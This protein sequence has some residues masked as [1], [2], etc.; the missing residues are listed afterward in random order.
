MDSEITAFIDDCVANMDESKKGLTR[1]MLEQFVWY[2]I[3]IKALQKQIEEEGSLIEVERGSANHQYKAW[4]EN[5]A[6]K[7]ISRYTTQ[8]GNHYA[9]LMRY[10]TKAEM[11][12]VD[13][14]EDFLK[15]G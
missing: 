5:P 9:K 3:Q 10:L 14:L 13:A 2:N 11:E 4:V 12:Q 8:A 15:N 7:V 6:A 1:P